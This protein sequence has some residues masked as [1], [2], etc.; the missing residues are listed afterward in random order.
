MN[1]NHYQLRDF[2]NDDS[3]IRWVL[4]QQNDTFWQNFTADYPHLT[5]PLSDARRLVLK[6]NET[7]QTELPTLD[8]KAVWSKIKLIM[9]EAEPLPVHAQPD[10]TP[11]RRLWSRPAWQWAAAALVVLVGTGGWFWMQQQTHQP[12]GYQELIATVDTPD[13]LIEKVNEGDSTLSVRLAD[14]ST[15]SLAKNSRLSYPRQFDKNNRTVYL[16]GEAFFEVTKDPAKPF[17][18]Y[19]NEVVTKVLGTS[20]NVRAFEQDKQVLV[21]VRT[22]RVSVYN[23]RRIDFSDPETTGLVLQPNQQAVF[24]RTTETLSKRLVENPLPVPETTPVVARLAFDEAPATRVLK[25]IEKRYGVKIVFNEEVLSTCIITTT[26]DN[27]SLYDQLDLICKTIGATYK[28]VDA[29]V[30]LEAAGCL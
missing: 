12:I 10:S 7:E 27:E 11:V 22:G 1:Y 4:F 26:L 24:S 21:N 25:A 18:V 6:I 2:L 20:F 13:A 14:G 16:S 30:V 5:L 9:D 23:Q 29:Q 15:V 8:E 28:E 17:F 19:A 3:F